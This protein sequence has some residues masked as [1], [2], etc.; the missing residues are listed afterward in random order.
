[1]Q[2][3]LLAQS[4]FVLGV[5]A[6]V[7]AVPASADPISDFYKANNLT[8]IVAS[9]VG[10]GYDLYGRT[11]ARHIGKHI[12]GNP[13]V[14]VQNMEGAGGIKGINYLAKVAPKDGSVIQATYGTLTIRP[15]VDTTGIE[16]DPLTLRWIGSSGTQ[17]NTCVTWS[18]SPIKTLE[19]AKSRDVPAAA[20]G[21]DASLATMP[22]ILNRLVG[23]KFKIIMGYTSGGLRV[24]LEGGEV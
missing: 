4:V 9:G 24:A 6:V 17:V 21:P 1:M 20:T 13:N 8:L 12:S 5:L 19:Q 22:N 16:Y 23:T 18:T 11:L 10:G 3:R 7:A 14:V 2:A 15:L